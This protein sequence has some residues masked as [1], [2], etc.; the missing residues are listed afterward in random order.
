MSSRN[1]ELSHEG[2]LLGA[3]TLALSDRMGDSV[4]AAAGGSASTAA[5]LSSLAEFLDGPTVGRLQQVVGLTPSGAVRLVDRLQGDGLVSRSLGEDR[6]SREVSLT[7]RGRRGAE[8]VRNARAG[9]LEGALASLSPAERR[10]LDRLLAKILIGLRRPPG[11]TRWTCRLCDL[12]ACGRDEGRCPFTA[13]RA[14]GR[15]ASA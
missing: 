13:A 1:T 9:V 15:H 14:A 7:A 10:T 8:K 12:T 3:L 5:A 4:R 6:R 11:A 2:N